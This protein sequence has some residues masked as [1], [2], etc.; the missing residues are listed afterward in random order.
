MKKRWKIAEPLNS[1]QQKI[2]ANIS[3]NLKCP[4]IIS[5]IL[6]RKG[7]SDINEIQKFFN[8]KIE[9]THD[10]FLFA[11]MEKAVSR[12]LTAIENKEKISIYGDYDV[13]GTTSTSLLYLG[14]KRLDA[15]I[16]FFIPHRMIDGYGLSMNGIQQIFDNGTK[17]IITVDCGINAI[18]EVKEI[19]KMGI[20]VIITDHHNPKEI[21]PPAFS[22]INPKL[23]NSIYPYK[24]LAGVGVAFKLLIAIYDK[25]GISK[26]KNIG[27]FLDF[28]ALGTIADIV[29]LTGENRIFAS[30]GI[31]KL[32]NKNNT[33]LRALINSAG[34]SKKELTTTDIVFGLAPRIN[35]AGRMGS[36]T[37]SVQ[38]LISNDEQESKKLAQIIEMENTKRQDID[39]RT[40]REACELIEK[41]YPVISETHSIVIASDGWHAGVIGIVA[42]KLVEKYYR[43]TIMISLKDGIGNGSGR[44]ISDFDLFNALTTLEDKLESFGGHKYAAGLSILSEY[45]EPFSKEFDEYAKQHIT[46]KQLIPPLKIDTE[47]ELYNINDI[48]LEWLDKFAPFGPGNMRPVF[49]TKDVQVVGYPYNVGRNH[50]KLKVMKDGCVFDL[51]GF[52]QGNL[53]PIIKRNNLLSI[54]YSLEVNT[55]Q[56]KTTIQGKLKDIH[57]E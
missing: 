8:P 20:D 23:I 57:F 2:K 54:A 34:L 29:P 41:K 15:D 25:K 18:E 12:I 38:L 37:R 56:G 40:F 43:P 22:V 10:P 42:S 26:E 49:Y 52:N 48:L 50:L 53:L 16:D 55:W 5:E 21:V 45:I 47:L 27:K 17:L 1:D 24:E 36:A 7:L 9:D 11:D 44:S 13:D 35:A 19:N 14:L 46:E 3:E 28:V 6:I 30:V 4:A 32:F 31:N 39:Q 51:I 33:G